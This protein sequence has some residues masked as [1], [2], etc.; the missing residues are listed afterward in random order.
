MEP[1]SPFSLFWY[2]VWNGSNGELLVFRELGDCDG[3]FSCIG[4]QST[5][6]LTYAQTDCLVCRAL[7][8]FARWFD[9]HGWSWGSVQ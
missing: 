1:F 4:L 6:L 5:I 7:G 3:F 2:F 9:R 8:A